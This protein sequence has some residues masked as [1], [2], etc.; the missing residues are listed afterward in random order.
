MKRGVSAVASTVTSSAC[1]VTGVSVKA[2]LTNAR[3][4]EAIPG[5]TIFSRVFG[6]N[7]VMFKSKL[8]LLNHI[9][10]YLSK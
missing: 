1:P 2:K 4:F 3:P 7:R 5:P 6:K 9:G 10:H 8:D